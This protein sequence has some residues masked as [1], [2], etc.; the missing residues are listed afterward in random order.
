MKILHTLF[1]LL[2]FY[3]LFYLFFKTVFSFGQFLRRHSHKYKDEVIDNEDHGNM[4][5]DIFD[6]EGVM[7]EFEQEMDKFEDIVD[8]EFEDIID[9]EFEKK[10]GKRK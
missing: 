10:K 4:S 9:A 7:D 6:V 3:V 1:T 5:A 8:A 2:V